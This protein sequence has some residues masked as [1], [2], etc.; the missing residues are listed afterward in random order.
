MFRRGLLFGLGCV[1]LTLFL[2]GAV[3]RRATAPVQAM[4]R[5]GPARRGGRSVGQV[6]VRQIRGGE[7]LITL[8][9]SFNDMAQTVENWHRSP[10]QGGS[11]RTSEL[12]AQKF[13]AQ[14]YLD[15]AGVMIPGPRYG[16]PGGAHQPGR[17]RTPPGGTGKRNRRRR[18]V[19]PTSSPN[20]P[21]AVRQAFAALVA[22]DTEPVKQYQN[23]ILTARPA[24]RTIAWANLRCA[25]PKGAS[26]APCPP[27]WTSPSASKPIGAW[28]YRPGK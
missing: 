27:G 22:G 23:D 21:T 24:P 16:G 14:R 26:K 4:A 12:E 20:P 3:T 1:V 2:V 19:L 18:L 9:E 13:L 25:T 15:V 17:V 28:K 11:G 6:E 7:E 8:A 10:G 5:G